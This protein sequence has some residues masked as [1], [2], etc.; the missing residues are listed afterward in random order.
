MKTWGQR[1]KCARDDWPNALKSSTER[2]NLVLKH[3][4]KHKPRASLG[5]TQI[6][7]E[8]SIIRVLPI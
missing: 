6:I 7:W 3:I 5:K 2:L 8:V 4:S 1:G